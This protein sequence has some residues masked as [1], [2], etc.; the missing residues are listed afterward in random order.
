MA[1]RDEKK[2]ILVASF[3]ITLVIFILA[4]LMNYSFDFFRINSVMMVMQEH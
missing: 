1:S 2:K 3:V 4:I